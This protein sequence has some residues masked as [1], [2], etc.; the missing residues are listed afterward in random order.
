MKQGF[1]WRKVSHCIVIPAVLPQ[2]MPSVQCFLVPLMVW[3][4][5]G[6]LGV[7]IMHF[8]YLVLLFDTNAVA[9]FFGQLFIA[10]KQ[11]NC[12]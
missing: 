3:Y 8:K 6:L 9:H 4:H 7:I 2:N 12:K 5:F 1:Y 10:L 11:E